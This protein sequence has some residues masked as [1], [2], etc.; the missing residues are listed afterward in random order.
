MHMAVTIPYSAFISNETIDLY[1][2]A[3]NAR[4]EDISRILIH[5]V[6]KI[7]AFSNDGKQRSEKRRN[8]AELSNGG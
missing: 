7:E 6:K 3:K 2:D 4:T 5:I 1:V 8:R